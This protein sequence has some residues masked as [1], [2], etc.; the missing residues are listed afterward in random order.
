MHRHNRILALI[1]ITT[2]A[3]A[4][5]T[6]TAHQTGPLPVQITGAASNDLLKWC[7]GGPGQPPTF[8]CESGRR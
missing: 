7:R 6:A 4:Y 2:G 5:T 3:L 1:L 8:E